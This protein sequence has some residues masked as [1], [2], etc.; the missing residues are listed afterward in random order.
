MTLSEVLQTYITENHISQRELARRCGLSVGYLNQ[1]IQGK[2]PRTG[3]PIVPSFKKYLMMCKGMNTNINELFDKIKDSD[4]AVS[5]LEEDIPESLWLAANLPRNPVPLL[6]SVAAG[7]AIYDPEVPGE[8]V[9]SPYE[10]DYALR[11]SG[12]SMSPTYLDGDLVYIVE[13]EDVLDGQVAIVLIDDSETIKHVYHR[14]DGLMLVSDNPA[15][16]PMLVL[17]RD[18][19]RI[20][21]LGVPVG[22]TRMFK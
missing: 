21:V 19:D 4:A 8:Y 11:I 18:H 15:Y 16:P 3:K 9:D 12:D 17:A 5:I 13:K 7:S 22:Y 10:A 14:T 6:G 2:H 20:R 1:L